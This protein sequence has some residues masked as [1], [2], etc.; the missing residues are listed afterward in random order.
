MLEYTNIVSQCLKAY[1]ELK[2]DTDTDN[3]QKK[4]KYVQLIIY[5]ILF[6]IAV[7]I[8]WNYFDHMEGFNK[9]GLVALAGFFNI[10]FILFYLIN[11][12]ALKN[13]KL[14]AGTGE[15]PE[16]ESA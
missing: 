3:K 9:Y 8:A 7:V 12:V 13:P 6:V 11:H 16:P 10:P 14:F 5:L 15:S 1:D 4:A 2:D